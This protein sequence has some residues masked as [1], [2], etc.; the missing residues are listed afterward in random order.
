M[1]YKNIILILFAIFFIGQAK[2]FENKN[3]SIL[4]K[5]D[6]RALD[7]TDL[8][9]NQ[10]N[11]EDINFFS[12]NFNPQKDILSLLDDTE[13]LLGLDSKDTTLDFE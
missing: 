3:K 1:N 12:E 4:I 6:N 11:F 8:P 5:G 7:V 13:L 10:Y 2:P 9:L